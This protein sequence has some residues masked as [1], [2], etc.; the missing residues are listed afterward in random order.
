MSTKCG[1]PCANIYTRRYMKDLVHFIHGQVE[2]ELVALK[3]AKKAE[4]LEK[5]GREAV[6]EAE[7]LQ[8]NVSLV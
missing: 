4:A 2:S 3:E 5:Y 1:Q 6:G 8:A 7:Q